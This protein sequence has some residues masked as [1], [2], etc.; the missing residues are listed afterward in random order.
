MQWKYQLKQAS[1]AMLETFLWGF[2]FQRLLDEGLILKK[3][4]I[5]FLLD[6]HSRLSRFINFTLVCTISMEL[7]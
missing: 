2:L 3:Q 4:I 1:V 7:I 6:W 5:A